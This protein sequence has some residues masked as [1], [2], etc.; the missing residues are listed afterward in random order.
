MQSNQRK[1]I[2]DVTIVP[3]HSGIFSREWLVG[4]AVVVA[5]TATWTAV[6]K[7]TGTDPVTPQAIYSIEKKVKD[8]EV[9]FLDVG[10]GDSIFIRTPDDHT[11][12][13]DAGSAKNRYAAFDAGE[14]AI[15]PYLKS[16]NCNRIDTLVM[17]HPHADHFGGMQSLLNAV[18]IGEYLDPGMNN[19]VP[20]YFTLLEMIKEKE[21]V[22]REVQAPQTLA[23]DPEI[24]VQVLWPEKGFATEN[25]NDISIVLRLVYGDVVYLLAGDV[26]ADIESVLNLYGPQLRTTVTEGTAPWKQY[27]I[28]TDFSGN[29]RPAS[30]S[31]QCRQQQSVRSPESRNSDTV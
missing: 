29:N 31:D 16:R 28:I 11:V 22:Y 17:T 1:S 13:I 15:L 25:P 14:H 27:L 4:L 24:L 6:W 2:N 10:Q 23:W 18:E 30:G 5:A 20:S 3:V 9:V 21:I 7:A 12:L 8:L 26:E 19:P